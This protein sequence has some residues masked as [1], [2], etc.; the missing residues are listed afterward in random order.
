[1]IAPKT[2]ALASVIAALL[3]SP[4]AFAWASEGHGVT[5]AIAYRQLSPALKTKVDALLKHHPAAAEWD[6]DRSKNH[7]I[8]S[9]GEYRFLRGSVWPDEVKQDP[10]WVNRATWHYV[11]IPM[12]SATSPMGKRLKAGRIC[13]SASTRPRRRCAT[14]L[15]ATRTRRSRSAS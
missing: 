7:T 11:N 15:R 12:T 14:P 3:A 1:M 2:L 4:A 10:A 8:M 5:A 13:S 9:R 6:V